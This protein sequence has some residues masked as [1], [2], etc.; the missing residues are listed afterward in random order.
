MRRVTCEDIH[1]PPTLAVEI[2]PPVP[3]PTLT[4]RERFAIHSAD[5]GCAGCHNKIDPVGFS[6]EQFDGMGAYRTQENSRPIDSTGTVAL[7][8]DFDGPY[9][10]SSQLAAAMSTSADVAECFARQMFR[11]G[12]GEGSGAKASEEAFLQSWNKLDP[13]D[14]RSLLGIVVALANPDL[15]TYWIKP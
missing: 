14:Q 5:A 11:A 4:T 2:I 6:F 12:S 1:L 7:N 3:D 13:A 8:K 9:G 15:M 10:S